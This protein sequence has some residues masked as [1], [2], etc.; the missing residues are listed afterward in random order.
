MEQ[1]YYQLLSPEIRREIHLYLSYEDIVISCN[2]NP[3][4]Q[5][6]CDDPVF[7]ISKIRIDFPEITLEEFGDR[8]QWPDGNPRL[9]YLQLLSRRQIYFPESIRFISRNE[10][11]L[12]F[13]SPSIQKYIFNRG[14]N[15]LLKII[16]GYPGKIEDIPLNAIYYDAVLVHNNS[17]IDYFL[18]SEDP[19]I[20][21]ALLDAEEYY[22]SY[23]IYALGSQNPKLR[24]R[25]IDLLMSSDEGIERLI[26]LSAIID[27]QNLLLDLLFQYP[28]YVGS[29]YIGA[30]DG[31][32]FETFDFI[33]SMNLSREA[34]LKGI[35]DLLSYIDAYNENDI[36]PEQ[37]QII[38]KIDK[39]LPILML[40]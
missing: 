27:D 30:F 39:Y 34:H 23:D 38:Y 26:Y 24:Q 14:I 25:I 11:F 13:K 28:Q 7:W 1:S 2:S 9:R 6:L 3:S 29:G 5:K 37:I 40:T 20:N 19:Y 31:S 8:S 12:Y 35:K 33:F 10:M 17:V 21:N 18:S 4:L 15:G 16:E 32:S 22:E 36:T